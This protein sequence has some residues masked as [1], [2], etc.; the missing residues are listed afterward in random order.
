MSR[1]K[2][3]LHDEKA[4]DQLVHLFNSWRK[5]RLTQAAQGLTGHKWHGLDKCRNGDFPIPKWL[6]SMTELAYMNK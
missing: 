5:L 3:E 1:K 6:Q 2:P 4:R